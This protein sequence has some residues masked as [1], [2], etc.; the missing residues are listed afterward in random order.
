MNA[1]AKFY[2]S[3]T[4]VLAIIVGLSFAAGYRSGF[5]AAASGARAHHATH[6]AP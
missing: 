1:T 3:L 6:A 4:V 2:T 5:H